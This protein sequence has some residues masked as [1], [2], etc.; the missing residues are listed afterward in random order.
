VNCP[1]HLPRPSHSSSE[2]R[3]PA[4][5]GALTDGKKKDILLVTAMGMAIR[6]SEE[7][8]RPMD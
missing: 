1:A 6:F 5:L 7:D 3:R 2:R 4:R 8:V